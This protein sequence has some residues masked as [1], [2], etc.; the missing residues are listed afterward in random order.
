MVADEELASGAEYVPRRIK[1]SAPIRYKMKD[2]NRVY[3]VEAIVGK[4]E[5]RCISL[6]QG[7]GV[8]KR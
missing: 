2:M 1:R 5:H 3:G 7:D 8:G 6:S 4:G